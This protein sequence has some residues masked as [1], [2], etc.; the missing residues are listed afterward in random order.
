VVAVMLSFAAETVWAETNQEIEANVNA[1]LIRFTTEVKGGREM[2]AMAQGVLVMPSVV[3]AGLIVGGEYGEG[4]LRGAGG[5]CLELCDQRVR[6]RPDREL[7]RCEGRR[8]PPVA[9]FGKKRSQG[10]PKMQGCTERCW[11]E[12]KQDA[13]SIKGVG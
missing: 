8:R 6:S 5:S 12:I 1:C 11:P 9:V 10:K 7:Q 4:A 2:L 3:K 13:T